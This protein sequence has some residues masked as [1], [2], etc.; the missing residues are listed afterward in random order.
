M[1]VLVLPS[2]R[3]QCDAATGQREGV[4]VMAHGHPD[5]NVIVIR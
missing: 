2:L 3:P 1:L 5:V 4:D